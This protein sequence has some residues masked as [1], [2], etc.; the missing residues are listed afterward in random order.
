[1]GCGAAR[2]LGV[3]AEDEVIL[4]SIIFSIPVFCPT[5][6]LVFS[7]HGGRGVKKIIVD[8]HCRMVRKRRHAT[9]MA[10]SKSKIACSRQLL[11]MVEAFKRAKS[12]E[13]VGGTGERI[14]RKFIFIYLFIDI[15][16]YTI[17]KPMIH[18]QQP[19]SSN[20]P[21]PTSHHPPARCTGEGECVSF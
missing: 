21:P 9:P 5:S 11:N 14:N 19:T 17:S 15:Y 16:I 3:R 7:V 13:T 18:T 1:L 10:R 12:L 2:I 6:I 8:A 20:Q 4:D